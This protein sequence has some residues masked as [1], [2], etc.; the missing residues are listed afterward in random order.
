VLYPYDAVFSVEQAKDFVRLGF[1]GN[2]FFNYSTGGGL[3][4]R[5]FAG[6]FIYT[7]KKSFLT[8]FE[9][10]RYHLNMSGANGY[11]DYTYNNYFLGR[12]ESEGF[13]SQ[14]IMMKDGGFKVK[15]DLLSDKVGKSD[16]WLTAINLCTTIPDKYNPLNV[17][18]VKLPVRLF[19]DAGMNSETWKNN[20]GTESIFFDAGF[21]LS[22]L[23]N[24]INIYFP[25]LYSKSFREYFQ[26]TI[27]EKRFAKTISFSI[28]IQNL[29]I[30][31][32]I[33]QSPF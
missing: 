11:E 7:V 17:L 13:S 19:A 3:S 27:S 18:P 32:I 29:S 22:F 2:Y 33:P 28:D 12:S 8:Q 21:Q 20:T 26:S 31:K 15:T 30:K 10:E 16:N 9:T 1:T 6:K 4:Y 23:K 14:Q 25:I 24:T 5:L